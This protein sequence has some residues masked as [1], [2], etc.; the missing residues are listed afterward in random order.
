MT[1]VIEVN[2][3]PRIALI[4]S[5]SQGQLAIFKSYNINYNRI[6]YYLRPQRTSGHQRARISPPDDKNAL[7]RRDEENGTESELIPKMGN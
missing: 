6:I 7:G 1:K 5:L 4:V 2:G 3:F